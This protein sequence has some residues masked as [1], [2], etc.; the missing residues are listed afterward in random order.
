[1]SE[2]MD[3]FTQYLGSKHGFVIKHILK[4]KTDPIL[5]QLVSVLP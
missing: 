4:E 5:I 1:M 3:H 2:Y